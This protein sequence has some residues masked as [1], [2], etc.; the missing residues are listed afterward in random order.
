M[1]LHESLLFGEAGGKTCCQWGIVDGGRRHQLFYTTV[2]SY[3]CTFLRL[4]LCTVSMCICNTYTYTYMYLS[5][6]R[7]SWCEK[8]GGIGQ[9]FSTTFLPSQHSAHRTSSS[10]ASFLYSL[11]TNYESFSLNISSV[12]FVWIACLMQCVV[13]ILHKDI[14]T[15]PPFH[16]LFKQPYL[17]ICKFQLHLFP[18]LLPF[19][20]FPIFSN[21]TTCAGIRS[22]LVVVSWPRRERGV[23]KS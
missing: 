18:P 1:L 7:D 6:A 17:S 12:C 21:C 16:I 13:I 4:Y 15:L 5:I 2:F 22:K 10:S 20:L 3:L 19:L 11:S 8:E 9:L 14:F 23:G